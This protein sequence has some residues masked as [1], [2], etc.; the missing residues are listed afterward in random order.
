[1]ADT[2][3]QLKRYQAK[4]K[5]QAAVKGLLAINKL[6]RLT[7]SE[8]LLESI[9]SK[10]K[11]EA[12]RDNASAPF[13]GPVIFT[14][15]G[16]FEADCNHVKKILQKHAAAYLEVKM[17]SDARYNVVLR[18]LGGGNTPPQVFLGHEVVGGLEELQGLDESGMLKSKLEGM[19]AQ[20]LNEYADSD[21]LIVEIES[22]KKLAKKD[23]FASDPYVL[24]GIVNSADEPDFNSNPSGC[25]TSYFSTSIKKNTLNPKFSCV[26]LQFT[27]QNLAGKFLRIECWDHDKMSADDFMGVANIPIGTSSSTKERDFPLQHRPAAGAPQEKVSGSISLR[28]ELFPSG[29][30]LNEANVF[31][32]RANLSKRVATHMMQQKLFADAKAAQGGRT[33]IPK[34]EKDSKR[35]KSKKFSTESVL[36]DILTAGSGFAGVLLEEPILTE[37]YPDSVSKIGIGRSKAS[38]GEAS[39][40]S[41]VPPAKKEGAGEPQP[42]VLRVEQACL[43]KGTEQA[44]MCWLGKL[45]NPFQKEL[46]SVKISEQRQRP[47][48]FDDGDFVDGVSASDIVYLLVN[49]T[50][51]TSR[52]HL[53]LA[54]VV[55]GG[56]VAAP[57]ELIQFSDG[58]SRLP[59]RAITDVV[60][61]EHALL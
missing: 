57:R 61:T 2:L 40:S 53:G 33:V 47:T 23:L 44:S 20:V 22:G 45:W 14:G 39:T 11:E 60:W 25:G 41:A 42:F 58:E 48:F 13:F 30:H 38:Q 49:D 27:G 51:P 31:R 26:P 52:F 55:T 10:L 21:F 28:C 54:C 18:K 59:I 12:A 34:K 56:E 17:S 4:R 46:I 15:D 7:M 36:A 29:A 16:R 5:F 3:K 32:Q 19:P 1:M 43:A 50:C 9:E 35:A 24:V 6:K 37:Y 8:S